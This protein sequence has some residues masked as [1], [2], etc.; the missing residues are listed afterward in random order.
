MHQMTEMRT[1]DKGGQSDGKIKANK[2]QLLFY[3]IA[4]HMLWK[5]SILYELSSTYI[6]RL[7]LCGSKASLDIRSLRHSSILRRVQ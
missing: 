2:I 5:Q 4:F 7:T 6:L 3:L 1:D